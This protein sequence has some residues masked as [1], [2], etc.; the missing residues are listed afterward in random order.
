MRKSFTLEHLQQ[1][2]SPIEEIMPVRY[3]EED[4]NPNCNAI[5]TIAGRFSHPEISPGSPADMRTNR[6]VFSSLQ[7]SEEETSW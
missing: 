7:E 4:E 5:T 6:E 1:V 3:A 2:I